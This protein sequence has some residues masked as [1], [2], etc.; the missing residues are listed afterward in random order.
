M[1]ARFRECEKT[2]GDGPCSVH[3]L[4]Q[5]PVRKTAAELNA[6]KEFK[7]EKLVIGLSFDGNVVPSRDLAAANAAFR[8]TVG[9]SRWYDEHPDEYH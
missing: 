8:D 9:T 3:P 1:C 4:N 2:P 6:S 5:P 7:K